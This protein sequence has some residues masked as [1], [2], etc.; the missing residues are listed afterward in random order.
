MDAF[1]DK[2]VNVLS[3]WSILMVTDF[4][5]MSSQQTWLFLGSC[6]TII[7]YEFILGIVRVQDYFQAYYSRR[8]GDTRTSS[9]TN[10]AAVMEGKLK[11]KL[12]SLGIGC[13]CLSQASII[14]LESIAGVTGV[15]CLLLSIR[16]AHASLEHKLKARQL[17]NTTAEIKNDR[18]T[19]T[20][21]D[22]GKDN[23]AEKDVSYSG[24]ED[25]LSDQEKSD[26]CET[27][28][29]V[30]KDINK[31]MDQKQS[32]KKIMLHRRHSYAAWSRSLDRVDKVY[33]IG[34]FDLFH[35]GHVKLFQRLRKLGKQIIVGVHDSRSIFQ[36]KKRVPIDDT[37]TRMMNV[38][39][40]ADVVYCV[41]G[42]DPTPYLHCM[43]DETEE[44]TSMYVRGDDMPDFP[45]RDL[46][47]KLMP[48]QFLPYTQTVSSTK[49][50][51]E[52]YNASMFGPHVRDDN[53]FMFY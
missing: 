29:R 12:E 32:R 8:Y 47:E 40:Y 11:E 51:K 17:Q 15:V 24:T 22:S 26:E 5:H 13:L 33:T 35:E 30:T 3:L 28:D 41:H 39:K 43:F 9:S 2:I 46:T 31:Q 18:Q 23:Y 44:C 53:H 14:P 49:I 7:A 38:K 48:V 37:Y 6:S 20:N 10:T 42:T 50:R 36:L 19:D 4:T 1:C 27:A 21:D 25:N 45:A 52:M 16:L 34:C